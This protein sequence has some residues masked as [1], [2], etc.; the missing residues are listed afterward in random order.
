VFILLPVNIALTQV[1]PLPGVEVLTATCATSPLELAED[2]GVSPVWSATG[3]AAEGNGEIQVLSDF[4][5]E[6][7]SKSYRV[8]VTTE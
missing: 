3:A 4:S 2:T 1:Q 5:G 7:G 8:V 6:T